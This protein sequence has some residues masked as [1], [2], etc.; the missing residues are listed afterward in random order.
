MEGEGGKKE[1]A[2]EVSR[3]QAAKKE[4]TGEEEEEGLSREE[5]K[6]ASDESIGQTYLHVRFG[7]ELIERE[8][9]RGEK[10]G[11]GKKKIVI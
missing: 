2:D 1:F 3:A 10:S 11:E 6:R 5:E 7:E 9:E 8:R 4:S